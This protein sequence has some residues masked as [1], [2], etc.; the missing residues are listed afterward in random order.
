MLVTVEAAGPG[1][2][3][4]VRTAVVAAAAVTVGTT[5]SRKSHTPDA[6]T[7]RLAE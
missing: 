5:Y 2:P 6:V 1:T 7:G 3:V 4:T